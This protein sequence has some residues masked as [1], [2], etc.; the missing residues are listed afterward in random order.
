M[1]DDFGYWVLAI[2]TIVGLITI[3]TL[4]VL[5]LFALAENI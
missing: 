4:I 2:L 5:G 1:K 3:C